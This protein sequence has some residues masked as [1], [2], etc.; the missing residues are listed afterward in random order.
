MMA[1]HGI[2]STYNSGCRCNLCT[3]ANTAYCKKYRDRR[4]QAAATNPDTVS[5]GITGYINWGCRCNVCKEAVREHYIGDWDISRA[6]EPWTEDDVRL[7]LRD[8]VP[9]WVTAR[10]LK[11]TYQS[12]VRKRSAQRR[13]A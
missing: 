12:V 7:A 8:D 11:R 10:K 6:Q 9:V 1:T 13:A 2:K 5:H 4:V 3:E